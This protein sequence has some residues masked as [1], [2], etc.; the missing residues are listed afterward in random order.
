[1]SWTDATLADFGRQLGIDGLAFGP[2]GFV[3]F[4]WR[5]GAVLGIH[6][7]SEDVSIYLVR[8]LDYDRPPVLRRALQL[9]DWRNGWPFAVQAGLRGDAELVFSARL[10][11]R[12]FTLP[13][14][15]QAV[16]LLGRLHEQA[17]GQ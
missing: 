2:G 11:E 15:E 12:D 1:M 9:C 16:E 3:Q 13:A 5:D 4:D 8:Q 6:R 14:L 17:R 10:P 7:G